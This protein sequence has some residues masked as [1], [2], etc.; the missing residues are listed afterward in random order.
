MTQGFPRVLSFRP[1]TPSD[2][3]I[4]PTADERVIAHRGGAGLRPENT[5]SAFNLASSLGVR[6]LETDVQVTADGVAVCFHDDT[7]DRMT[8]LSGPVS[9]YTWDELQRA[10]VADPQHVD[11]DVA[12]QTDSILR[13]D[14]FLAE[15]TDAQI[16]IDVKNPTG[17]LALADAINRTDSAERVCVTHAWDAWLQAVCELTSPRLQRGLGWESL[18]ALIA[19]ARSGTTPDPSLRVANYAH[20]GWQIGNTRLAA[21]TEL[22]RRF[23]SMAHDLGMAV[24]VWTINSPRHM[25]RLRDDGVD[26]IFT[27][28]PDLALR[29]LGYTGRPARGSSG[30]HRQVGSE[31]R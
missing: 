15:F 10:T 28:F 2:P 6:V 9:S 3:L 31:A 13:L 27:D 8:D 23:I 7:L 26:A 4:P 18:A 30:S 19:A 22:R 14:D 12:G 21:D 17:V 29:T 24:R 5:R 16:I 20:L 25:V 11:T 1:G